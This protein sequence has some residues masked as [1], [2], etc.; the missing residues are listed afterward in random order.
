MAVG[1]T[2]ALNLASLAG[3]ATP[4]VYL[5]GVLLFVAGLAIVQAHNRWALAWPLLV[6]LAGWVL[7]GGGLYRMLAPAAP[8][9]SAGPASYGLLAALV[10]LG[11]VL[12]CK[13]YGAADRE[14]PGA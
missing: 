4:V 14:V 9:M 5:N 6:T 10:M 2:E 12:A 8:Q 3:S 11:G 7:L 1:G 13:G